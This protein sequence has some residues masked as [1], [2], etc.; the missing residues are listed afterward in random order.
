MKKKEQYKMAKK[1]KTN[2][3]S[4]GSHKV[5]NGRN[6]RLL[7][8]NAIFTPEVIDDIHIKDQEGRYRL[9]VMALRRKV[10]T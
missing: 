9:R 4:N 5:S 7:G 1:K 3:K 6:K 2:G 8:Q 10:P